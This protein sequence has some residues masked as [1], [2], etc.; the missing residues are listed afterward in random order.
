MRETE[1]VWRLYHREWVTVH[2]VTTTAVDGRPAFE[3]AR[4]WITDNLSGRVRDTDIQI[5][6]NTDTGS[7]FWGHVLVF[8]DNLK[9]EF[10]QASNAEV[11]AQMYNFEEYTIV[12]RNSEADH[13]I[14][15]YGVK[16]L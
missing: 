8:K 5:Q 12:P 10:K 11:F 7:T 2:T 13:T 9:G 4:T 16:K 1:D 15:S 3:A 6:L 14:R